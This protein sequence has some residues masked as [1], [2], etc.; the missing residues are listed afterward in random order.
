MPVDGAQNVMVNTEGQAKVADFG[1][2][3]LTD[4]HPEAAGMTM[5]GIVMGT[6]D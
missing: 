6:P 2:A 3:R 1:L 5:T 4:I